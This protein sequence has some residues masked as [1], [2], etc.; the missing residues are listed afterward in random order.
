MKKILLFVWIICG[1][2][3]FSFA[4]D[5]GSLL[6]STMSSNFI[7][8]MKMDIIKKIKLPSMSGLNLSWINMTG[9]RLKMNTMIKKTHLMS[10]VNF[11]GMNM[12]WMKMD[13]H[14]MML[15]KM[16]MMKKMKGQMMSWVN[17]S[18]MNM[19]WMKM[20]MNKMLDKSK[21]MI[22]KVKK[23]DDNVRKRFD[24]KINLLSGDAK[25]EFIKKLLDKVDLAIQKVE[26]SSVYSNVKK[27]NLIWILE[28][29]KEYLS[30]Q[31]NDGGSEV[32]WIIDEILS[33]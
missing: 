33:N 23:L 30:S 6:D 2:V 20:K 29:I 10:W 31:L 11:S 14:K 19:S 26:S 27:V 12:S 28:S 13:M 5:S 17:F 7:S 25:I 4:Q 22:K 1:F 3:S 9:M 21:W 8:W 16:D 32:S 15:E 18:G 24:Q